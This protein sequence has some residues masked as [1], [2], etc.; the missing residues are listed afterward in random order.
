MSYKA[1]DLIANITNVR[2]NPA[3]VQQYQL[4]AVEAAY[5]GDIDIV[6]A[7]NP[8]V[9]LLEANA[10][11]TAACMNEMDIV[12]RKLYPALATTQEDLYLHMTDTDYLN[13]F[14][15]PDSATFHFLLKVASV[16]KNVVAV[17][18]TGVSKIVIP[19]NTQVTVD[20]YNFGLE[21]PI[22]IRLM[23][24][25]SFQVVY[26]ND[27]ISPMESL[28][29]NLVSWSIKSLK[30]GDDSSYEDWIDIVVPLKQFTLSHFKSQMTSSAPFNKTYTLTDNYYYCRVYGSTDGTTWTEYQTT[31]S[32]Q[33]F[34][35]TTVTAVLSVG[36]NK[37]QV[38]IP[39]IYQTTGLV[40][41]QIRVDIYTTK[42]PSNIN[43]S[44]YSTSSF[45]AVFNDYDATDT[46]YTAPLASIDTPIYSD[47]TTSGGTAPLNFDTLR[48]QV[49]MKNTKVDTPI[50]IGQLETALT[51][52]DFNVIKTKDIITSRTYAASRVLPTPD[53]TSVLKS[54]AGAAVYTMEDTMDSLITR[55]TV[56]D[57]N[58]SITI[59]P[60]T[61]FRITNGVLTMLPEADYQSYISLWNNKAYDDLVAALG[62][63]MGKVVYTPWHY[64][65]DT[66]NNTFA[67]RPYYLDSPTISARNFI[68]ENATIAYSIATGSIAISRSSTGY[69]LTVVA[70]SDANY[71]N[72]SDDQCHLQLAYLPVGESD[73]A[74]MTG[75]LMGTVNGERCWQFQLNPTF[76]IDA[77]DNME[78]T[79]FSMYNGEIIKTMATLTQTF[80]LVW[81]LSGLDTSTITGSDID[82]FVYTEQVPSTTLGVVQES[83]ALQFGTAMTYLWRSSR[84]VK[85]SIQY[86]TYGITV[87]STYDEDIYLTN[88]A[89]DIE[90]VQQSDGS[91]L[92]EILH[93][94]GDYVLDSAGNRIVL[95]E[96][97]DVVE[98]NG[99]PVEL[100][101]RAI[102]RQ[103]DICVVDGLFYFATDINGVAYRKSLPTSVLAY[104][105]T[106]TSLND[107]LLENTALYYIPQTTL[108]DTTV[109]VGAGETRTIDSNL[110]FQ[111]DVYLTSTNYNSESLIASMK[112]KVHSVIYTALS[113]ATFSIDAVGSD[114]GTA[115]GEDALAV[116]VYP[117][118]P[119]K[120]ITVFTAQDNVTR[121][122]IKRKLTTLSD[123]TL[124]VQDDITV[125]FYNHLTSTASTTSA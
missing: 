14:S 32:D 121:P 96:A 119:D 101:V 66:A 83:V 48:E 9:F 54:G 102:A 81:E 88:S 25:G 27:I 56:I 84:T 51:L 23:P 37:L 111:V 58:T 114:I 30:S 13:R 26:T 10:C 47:D 70:A 5:D 79:G 72:L 34:D 45:S 75:T 28:V 115:L 17:G 103:I 120:D 105:E 44:N 22:D 98:V 113:D 99:S 39:Q 118:G 94:K 61:L 16:K 1:S 117:V 59:T 67:L 125:N 21:Y 91:Y 112:D 110:S 6:D 109:I 19:R 33:V 40:G 42:G 106:I 100:G 122:S 69:T 24:H 65:L 20:S 15:T 73:Y 3:L 77:D 4:N 7:T 41:S 53:D 116:Y 38:S 31:H 107:S 57:N 2:S 76:Y 95:H 35:A 123:G 46:A 52:D 36:T 108:G 50:T 80:Y 124:Q 82:N 49:I 97:T 8:F 11:S 90:L 29:S 63:D 55:S 68:A 74:Y 12:Y 92:A 93:R 87:Y 18:D 62:A 89:G 85:D 43:L 86:Q 64:V 104:L 78:M 71:K 60:S